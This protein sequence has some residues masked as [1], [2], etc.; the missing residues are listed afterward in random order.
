[1][2]KQHKHLE[3]EYFVNLAERGEFFAD[4]RDPDGNTIYEINGFD[5]VED[6]FMDHSEDLDGLRD[7][8]A[9]MGIV[10]QAATITEGN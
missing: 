4:V 9:D 8:L 2:K 7:Y 1:M 3:F 10:S 6:G 5:L